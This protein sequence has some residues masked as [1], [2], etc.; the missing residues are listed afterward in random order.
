VYP[1]FKPARNIP[2]RVGKGGHGGGDEPLMR[3]IFWNKPPKDPYMCA[4]SLADGVRSI[5]VGI[6]ANKS[7]RTGKPVKIA[8]L[9]K[10]LPPVR[11]TSMK[12]W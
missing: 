10:R 7:M 3:D 12:E 11:H 2:V 8:G 5:L 6:A 4:A 1:H 9:V